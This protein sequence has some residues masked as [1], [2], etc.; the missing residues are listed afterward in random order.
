MV[1]TACFAFVL[2]ACA[3]VPVCAQQFHSV[4]T[5]QEA[6]YSSWAVRTP[7]GGVITGH[8]DYAD[9]RKYDPQM[10]PVAAWEYRTLPLGHPLVYMAQLVNG[11]ILSAGLIGYEPQGQPTYTL[12]SVMRTDANG[13][14]LAQDRVR[15][16]GIYEE[17]MN[18]SPAVF[19]PLVVN[20]QGE[21]FLSLVVAPTQTTHILKLSADLQPLWV[22]ALPEHHYL[23]GDLLPD[24]AGGCFFASLRSDMQ[25]TAMEAGHLN[26]DGQPTAYNSYAHTGAH[27]SLSGQL[28]SGQ[29]RGIVLTAIDSNRLLWL[30]LDSSLH[31][32]AYKLAD[33]V[34]PPNVRDCVG[35]FVR[36]G[37]TEWAVLHG[38]YNPRLIFLNSSGNWLRA[39]TDTTEDVDGVHHYWP[40]ERLSGHGGWAVMVGNY[41]RHYLVPDTFDN[42]TAFTLMKDGEWDYCLARHTTVQQED[43]PLSDV[44]VMAIPGIT[45]MPM[46]TVEAGDATIAALDVWA[47]MDLCASIDGTLGIAPVGANG[48]RVGVRLVA[49]GTPLQWTMDRAGRTLL[50]D[51]QG[52]VL[53]DDRR[54]AGTAELPTSGLAPGMYVLTVLDDKGQRMLTTRVVVE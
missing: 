49:R 34:L 25:I 54:T 30:P 13:N 19:E 7:D 37:T 51:A 16:S 47:T 14:V 26:A 17:Q 15:L 6:T 10:Q 2:F 24:D 45:A 4:T 42:R 11:D 53:Q 23:A 5:V 22:A 32:Q 43:I 31:M 29:Q 52:R 44:A 18:T 35:G 41:S 38:L 3:A 21:G 39:Y 40:W 36:L 48:G 33:P 1:R 9:L 28:C 27:Y 12:L 8:A 50:L 20:G 46:P